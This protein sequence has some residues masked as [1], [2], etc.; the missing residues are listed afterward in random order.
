MLANEAQIEVSLNKKEPF[1]EV[2]L[3]PHSGC[4]N[5]LHQKWMFTNPCRRICPRISTFLRMHSLSWSLV[6]SIEVLA[7]RISTLKIRSNKAHVP[8]KAQF[9]IKWLT[10]HFLLSFRFSEVCNTL[11]AVVDVVIRFVETWYEET[12]AP[13]SPW[14]SAYHARY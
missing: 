4:C 3:R 9:K 1:I 6:S 5:T 13:S 14:I 7:N 12:S 10:R 8:K 2:A 11:L